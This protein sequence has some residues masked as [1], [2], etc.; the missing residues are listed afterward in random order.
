MDDKQKEK[1][2]DIYDKYLDMKVEEIFKEFVEKNS[3]E[4]QE[5][6]SVD[7]KNKSDVYNDTTKDYLT[8]VHGKDKDGK[9]KKLSLRKGKDLTTAR[10]HAQ[11]LLYRIAI[12]AIGHELGEK[13][14]GSYT[15]HEQI[16]EYLQSRL[17][18]PYDEIVD[19]LIKP[20]DILKDETVQGHLNRLA[21]M[22]HKDGRKVA[23]LGKQLTKREHFDYIE[24]E[25]DKMIAN[26]GYIFDKASVSKH[27]ELMLETLGIYLREGTIPSSYADAATHLKKKKETEQKYAMQKS[28]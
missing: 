7:V 24:A 8:E 18:K 12:R 25:I 9:P 14:T 3:K 4:Q 6:R 23:N 10:K 16:E 13:A 5:E 19:D 22:T 26:T 17:G 28:A 11:K 27:P 20:G 2:K 21:Q 1:K 15:T